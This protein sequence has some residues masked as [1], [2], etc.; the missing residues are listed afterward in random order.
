MLRVDDAVS[1]LRILEC[2]NMRTTQ[3]QDEMCHM[4]VDISS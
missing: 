1:C 4:N 2:L 3:R